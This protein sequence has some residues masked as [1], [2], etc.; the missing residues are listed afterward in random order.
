MYICP[1]VNTVLTTTQQSPHNWEVQTRKSIVSMASRSRFERS[2]GMAAMAVSPQTEL[3]LL[4]LVIQL[5]SDAAAVNSLRAQVRRAH[6]NATTGAEAEE[7]VQTILRKWARKTGR[8]VAGLPEAPAVDRRAKKSKG[9][10]AE[11]ADGDAPLSSSLNKSDK[12]HKKD[13]KDKKHK[14]K[15]EKKD[16]KD[17]KEKSERKA[18]RTEGEDDEGHAPTGDDTGV[19]AVETAEVGGVNADA[20]LALMTSSDDEGENRDS[21]AAD[22]GVTDA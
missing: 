10:R 21:A 17:K 16:K 12:K 6:F 13:K 22:T 19:D 8:A 7:A 2:E 9:H 20:L 15:K 5:E 18:H 4:Q 3:A 11:A 14:D 1:F